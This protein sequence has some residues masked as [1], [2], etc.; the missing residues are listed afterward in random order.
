MVQVSP[1]TKT[2]HIYILWFKHLVYLVGSYVFLLIFPATTI[3]FKTFICFH[4]W[5][6]KQKKVTSM[7]LIMDFKN[8]LILKIQGIQ[9][10][11]QNSSTH[12]ANHLHSRKQLAQM[13]PE[14]L[15][16]LLS[17]QPPCPIFLQLD[18]EGGQFAAF[19]SCICK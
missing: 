12:K 19:Y 6:G 15:H 11:N 9:L 7:H 16:K 5:F 1:A 4:I 2:Q 14:I 8:S 17:R 13:F 18:L 10:C 3:I